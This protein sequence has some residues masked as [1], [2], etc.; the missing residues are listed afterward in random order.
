M[1]TLCIAITISCFIASPIN[2]QAAL[3]RLIEMP[4]HERL[5]TLRS[6]PSNTLAP[7]ETDGCSGYQSQIW[8]FIAAQ[9]PSFERVHQNQPPWQSCCVTHDRAYHIGG[10]NRD[11]QASFD[12][13]TAADNQLHACVIQTAMDRKS[14]LSKTYGMTETQVATAYTAIAN[15]MFIAVRVGGAPCSGLAWRW[16]YGYTN[17]GVFD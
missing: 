16:G 6:D 2:A 1:K 11:A 10:F 8:E 3:E 9:I 17:C 14:E 4:A 12:A 15:T 7:F 13:R 5:Q